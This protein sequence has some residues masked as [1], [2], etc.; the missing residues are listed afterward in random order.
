MS[1]RN[2][3]KQRSIKSNYIYNLIY[4]VVSL[5]APLITTP[6]LSRILH[7]DGIGIYSFTYSIASYFVILG[8]LGVAT[9]GQMEIARVHENQRELSKVFIELFLLRGILTLV[10]LTIYIVFSINSSSYILERLI[11]GIYVFSSVLDVSWLFRGVEDFSKVVIRNVVVKLITIILIFA[12][13]KSEQDT[14]LYVLLISLSTLIG[15]LSFI[16]PTRRIIIRIPIK[17]IN[18]WR[19]L[20]E[21]IVF[22]VPTIA[23]SV[24]TMLDKTMLGYLSTD[25]SQNGFYEQAHKIEQ[26][27]LVVITSLNIIMR[28]RMSFLFAKGKLDEMRERLDQS[29]KYI[30][31]ISIPMTLGIVG[32]AKTFIPLFLGSGYEECV[33]LLQ[34]FSILL[35]VIG[36]SN[37]LNTHFL[38]PSGRQNKNNVVLIAGAILNFV[39]NYLWIP[40][41]GA[42]GASVAS[43]IAEVVI[44]AGY[45]Y[46]I[47]DF[48]KGYRLL[49]LGWKY[50]V[51]GVVMI[52]IVLMMEKSIDGSHIIKL[53]V[54]VF[55]GF[56][57]YFGLLIVLKDEML[58]SGYNLVKKKILHI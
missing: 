55:A 21:C 52:C 44:L 38:G 4:E 37:C 40:K 20:R 58:K 1:E 24:Y 25:I 41:Y 48:F 16:I 46:L 3:I 49:Q 22:F 51:S 26:I 33:L 28:S 43:V 19:N 29:L 57:V 9:Y 13:V 17:E 8:N 14:Y 36:I 45:L 12:I 53:F 42:L 27:L 11:L 5:L 50:M 2:Q 39:L 10:S 32:I 6:Y 31:M 54:Q 47:R 7:A 30:L 18:I 35:V 56:I 23:T 34:I 15:N